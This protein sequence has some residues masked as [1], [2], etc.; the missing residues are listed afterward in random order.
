MNTQTPVPALRRGKIIIMSAPSG[1][2]KSTII[3]RLM[4]DPELR[5][6]FS[7]SATSRAPRGN[8]KHGKEYYFLTADEFAQKA[9]KGEFVEY[10]EVYPGT[11]YGTLRSEVERVLSSGK[12]LIM[13]ID[14]QGGV[15]VKQ[16]F[17]ANAC[18]IFVM[19]PS[20]DALKE[21]LQSRGS[22]SAESIVK[23][24]GKAQYEMTFA[25]RFDSQVVNDNL[26]TAVE[27]TRRLIKEFI[28]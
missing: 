14:V 24:L 5:L 4:S 17:G 15:N 23:R 12:N 2:G 20:I 3:E 13:D 27:D 22:D 21:R 9:R 18:S 25:P 7:I 10:E 6:G 26:D 11:F 19:P 28:G 8:E 16:R 1:A